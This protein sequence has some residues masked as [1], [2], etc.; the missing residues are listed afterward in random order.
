MDINNILFEKCNNHIKII[1]TDNYFDIN[2]DYNIPIKYIVNEKIDK[3]CLQNNLLN[4]KLDWSLYGK[5]DIISGNILYKDFLE[6]TENNQNAMKVHRYT[7]EFTK[8]NINSEKYIFHNILNNSQL[9]NLIQ[10]YIPLPN[11]ILNKKIRI[12]RFYSGYKYSGSNIHNHTKALNYLIDGIKLWILFPNT[13]NNIKFLNE[14]LLNY[15]SNNNTPLKCFLEYYN[16]FNKNIENISIIIQKE[17]EVIY[18]PD[19]YFHSVINLE[20]SY[21]IIYSW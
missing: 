15:V 12:S 8:E 7:P 16:M 19:Y 1:N 2:I 9:F 11:N 21:G 4:Y 20:D 13:S 6:N 17:N 10:K 14:N 5:S 3:K 18:I